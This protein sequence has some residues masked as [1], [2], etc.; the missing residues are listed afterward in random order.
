[1]SYTSE[2]FHITIM[3]KGMKHRLQH[4]CYFVTTLGAVV[5]AGTYLKNDEILWRKSHK[6]S[7]I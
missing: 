6:Y 1:M 3:N 5:A 4:D 2:W 7:K